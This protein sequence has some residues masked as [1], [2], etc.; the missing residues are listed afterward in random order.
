MLFVIFEEREKQMKEYQISGKL[1][2]GF[3][4]NISYEVALPI[5]MDQVEVGVSF[6]KRIMEEITKEDREACIKAYQKNT[7]REPEENEIIKMIHGQKTEINVSV[8]HN[9]AYLGCAH[10]DEMVKKIVISPEKASEG[11]CTWKFHGGV[12]KIVLH[13]YQVLNQNTPYRVVI[14]K[15][16]ML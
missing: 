1:M 5:E 6:E 9:E 2:K 4:G 3:I 16:E 13:V 14:K 7:G 11:F 10:R 12:L 8:F 15:G